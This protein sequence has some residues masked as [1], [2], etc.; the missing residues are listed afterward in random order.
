MGKQM[1]HNYVSRLLYLNMPVKKITNKLHII[2]TQFMK[3]ENDKKNRFVQI[4]AKY[5]HDVSKM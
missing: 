2:Y 1:W 3:L 5:T 4:F